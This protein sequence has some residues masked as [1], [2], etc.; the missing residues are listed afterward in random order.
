MSLPNVR[1]SILD[2]MYF[3]FETLIYI[4]ISRRNRLIS[5]RGYSLLALLVLTSVEM[6]G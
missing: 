4:I 6:I 5:I 1:I 3:Y 2:G